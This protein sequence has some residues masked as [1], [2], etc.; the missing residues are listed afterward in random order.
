MYMC[1]YEGIL[2]MPSIL[3]CPAWSSGMI[4]P[5]PFVELK[6]LTRPV[7][8]DVA[9]CD[10]I[11]A[12]RR[13]VEGRK[14]KQEKSLQHETTILDIFFDMLPIYAKKKTRARTRAL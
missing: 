6:N 7:W 4:K 12:I 5:Y 8:R 10:A 14:E 1:M 3:G 2:Y 9:A 11:I 13:R